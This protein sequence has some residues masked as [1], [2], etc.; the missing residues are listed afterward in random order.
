M[1]H[2]KMMGA[3]QPFIS[4]AISKTVNMPQTATVEDI[5]DAYLRAWNLMPKRRKMP[6]SATDGSID[7]G[8]HALQPTAMLLIGGTPLLLARASGAHSPRVARQCGPIGAL[9]RRSC[10]PISGTICATQTCPGV[11]NSA[12]AQIAEFSPCTRRRPISSCTTV[13][14]L[15]LQ[16]QT[17]FNSDCLPGNRAPAGPGFLKSHGGDSASQRSGQ[18]APQR[19]CAH[20]PGGRPGIRV[21]GRGWDR[22]DACGYL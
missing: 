20:A 22:P 17:S 14:A 7:D 15:N 19:G 16:M 3:V 4:G 9:L 10:P 1:G 5:A 13:G 6:A 8:A 18:P 12:W 11:P 21:R 2:L